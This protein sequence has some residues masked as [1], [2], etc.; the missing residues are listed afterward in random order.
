MTGREAPVCWVSTAGG[1][2]VVSPTLG[3]P[4]PCSAM[5]YQPLEMPRGG[6]NDNAESRKCHRSRADGLSV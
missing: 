2:M 5:S 4:T 1:Y 3:P 6:G